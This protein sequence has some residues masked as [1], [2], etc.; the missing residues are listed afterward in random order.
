MGLFSTPSVTRDIRSLWYYPR[1]GDTCCRAFGCE[2]L[3]QPVFKDFGLSRP[4]IEPRS[5]G[6]E[7]EPKDFRF[8]ANASTAAHHRGGS[9]DQKLKSIDR[10]IP[11]NNLQV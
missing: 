3:S 6:F 5:L 8:V 4:E 9:S 1:K 11:V 2:E 10:I 7:F